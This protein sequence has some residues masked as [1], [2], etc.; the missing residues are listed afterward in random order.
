MR[1]HGA[2]K[3][4]VT[5]LL[6]FKAAHLSELEKGFIA[7]YGTHTDGY[8]ATPGGEGSRNRTS[9]SLALSAKV[10]SK[11]NEL[12]KE[13]GWTQKGLADKIGIDQPFVSRIIRGDVEPGLVT[14]AS[15]AQA[16]DLTLSELFEGV[17]L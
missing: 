11:I 6:S 12:R 8:N 15:I 3:F 4:E 7:I 5:E 16:F 10:G 9:N 2:D 17:S 1:E 14:V 13:R